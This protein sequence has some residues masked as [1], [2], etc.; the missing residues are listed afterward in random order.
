MFLRFLCFKKRR[1]IRLP[2]LVPASQEKRIMPKDSSL[3]KKVI[4]NSRASTN[5]RITEVMPNVRMEKAII[6]LSF[7]WLK[8]LMVVLLCD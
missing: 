7:Y 2:M 1:P 8:K 3:P 6:F 5:C 4:C